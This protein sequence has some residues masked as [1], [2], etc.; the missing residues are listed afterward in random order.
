MISLI[1]IYTIA[2][3]CSYLSLGSITTEYL[4]GSEPY[5]FPRPMG[6][7]G[8]GDYKFEFMGLLIS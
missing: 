6:E 5:F 4:E 1:Y 7:F 8:I 2:S 3:V